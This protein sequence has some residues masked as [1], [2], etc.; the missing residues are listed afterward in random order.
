MVG[1]AGTGIAE[2]VEGAFG[3]ETE[4]FAIFF[5]QPFGSKNLCGGMVQ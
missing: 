3:L 4:E 1:K 2:A 5:L